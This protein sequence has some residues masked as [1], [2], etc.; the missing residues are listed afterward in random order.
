MVTPSCGRL[1]FPS[2][3]FIPRTDGGNPLQYPLRPVDNRVIDEFAVELD[4]RAALRFG[5]GKVRLDAGRPVTESGDLLLSRLGC[6]RMTQREPVAS[7][8]I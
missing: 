3:L 5:V 1:V 4:R 2:S 7:N 8:T 6:F